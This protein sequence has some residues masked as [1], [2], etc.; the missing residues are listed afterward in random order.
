MAAESVIFALASG[1]GRAGVAVM[2]LSG[3]GVAAVFDALTDRPPP[4][5]RM[6]A[7]R[8]LVNPDDGSALDQAL[9]LW[10]PAPASFTGEDVVELH[11]HGGIAV[12]DGVADALARLPGFRPAE[13]GEFS[14]RAF[15]NG[16]MDL[17]AA[18]GLADLIDADTAFARRRALWQME[19]GLSRIHNDWRER[20][21]TLLALAEAA[22]DFSDEPIPETLDLEIREGISTMLAEI[23][24]HLGSPEAVERGRDGYRIVLTGPPNVGKS[25]LLNALARRDAAIVTATPG[26][27]RD[28]LEVRMDLGGYPVSLFDTAGLRD[29]S[30]P[31]EQEGMRRARAAL[32][33]ADLILEVRILAAHDC[34][35]SVGE[36]DAAPPGRMVF[37]N[38]ADLAPGVAPPFGLTGSAQ[39]GAGLP[40]LE[41]ALA[42]LAQAALEAGPAPAMTRARHRA[43]LL[44]VKD[45]LDQALTAPAPELCAEDLRTAMRA[46]GRVVGVVDVD[47]V[48]DR[49]FSAFCIG[50]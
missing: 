28:V 29:S 33:T 44:D 37:W 21:L 14:R 12:I 27:T 17:A 2:R 19:G 50:K 45:A 1:A 31:I 7:L 30:D 4:P 41:A 46:L 16:K 39:S 23:A 40:A 22:L 6:A 5:P 42:G 43:A 32:E 18:E 35:T 3:P 20:L 34:G 15:R 10:F 11:L 24:R 49:I 48:L 36:A 13:P 8:R 38:K 9:T 25:S 26:T 47:D